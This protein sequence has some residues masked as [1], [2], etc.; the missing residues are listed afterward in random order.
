MSEEISSNLQLILDAITDGIIVVDQ[1]GKVL[2]ANHSAERIFERGKLIGKMLA[3]PVNISVNTPQEI[4]LL[5]PSG[6]GWAELRSASIKWQGQQSYVIGVRDITEN[7]F[8]D[9]RLRQ[10]AA[11]FE[12]THDGVM[13][14]DAK[15]HIIHINTAFTNITGYTEADALGKT[16][17]LLSSGR[18]NMEFY[19]QMWDSINT[20]GH[21]QGEIWNR[22]KNGEVYPELLSISAVNDKSDLI[23]HYVGVFA[24]ISKLKSSE[25]QLDF[26]AH[27]DPLTRLPNRLL[28]LSRMEHAIKI[29]QREQKIVALLMLDLDRF[30]EVNDHFGHL[31]GDELLQQ[32][33]QRLTARL[34]GIDTVCRLGGDEFTILLE[35]IHQIEDASLVASDVINTLREPW[36]LSKDTEV[37][38][39]ASVGISFY[40]D[41]GD[42]PEQLL[43]KADI[44]LFH[45]KAEGRGCFKYFSETINHAAQARMDIEIRLRK[46]I[47]EGELR[48]YYQPQLDVS[49]GRVVGAEA[50]V[51][52]QDPLNGLVSPTLFIGLAEKTGLITS[53]GNWVL[54]EACTQAQHWLNAGIPPLNINVNISPYQFRYSHIDKV[55]EA[56]LN[57]TGFPANY[58]ELE[59]T[60]AALMQHENEVMLVLQ[61]LHDLGVT[62]AIDNFGTG[63]SSLAHLKRFPLN[64]LK[65]DKCFVDDILK[66][67]SDKDIIVT[68]INIAHALHLKVLAEGVEKPEQL[69]FLQTHGCDLYQGYLISP[70]L[71]ATEFVELLEKING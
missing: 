63:Y 7:K 27:H 22:R 23:T 58:L 41:H 29:A 26:L 59:L 19:K 44:A 48:V 57:A 64:M 53:I 60:E 56:V 13:T 46:G 54:K 28:L 70:A 21:W 24:D 50:L 62:L 4:N 33:A 31:A 66:Q 9:D 49:T 30:K 65:I 40:P 18:H 42:D 32:V 43:Q 39:G 37:R 5:R 35:D 10:A 6:I 71:P 61:R 3:I 47:E 20:T 36:Q 17:S 11:V 2:Y 34:R 55:V 67:Q 68:I 45:A 52:W 51:R 16:P 69:E 38:I 8:N 15:L 1:L 14:V 25:I 12:N